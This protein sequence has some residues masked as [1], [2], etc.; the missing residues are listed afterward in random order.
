MTPDEDR[1]ISNALDKLTNENSELKHKLFSIRIILED[2]LLPENNA[3]K[4]SMIKDI[5]SELP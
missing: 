1:R 3:C 5:I 2:A 4:D